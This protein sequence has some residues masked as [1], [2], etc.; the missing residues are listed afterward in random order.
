MPGRCRRTRRRWNGVQGLG[1]GCRGLRCRRRDG[2]HVMSLVMLAMLVRFGDMRWWG[3]GARDRLSELSCGTGVATCRQSRRYRG[4]NRHQ[5]RSP[6]PHLSNL[7]RT[8]STEIRS[9]N[10]L[11][12][13]LTYGGTTLREGVPAD[14][15]RANGAATHAS[16]IGTSPVR[17]GLPTNTVSFCASRRCGRDL[18]LRPIGPS[19]IPARGLLRL[20]DRVR[21]ADGSVV[22]PKW[23]CPA[24]ALLAVRAQTL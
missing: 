17:R 21:R 19:A 5:K 13:D 2:Y 8:L 24:R 16:M 6:V 23:R 14:P 20:R 15:P 11:G 1:L 10:P 7:K 9:V 3:D 22:G 18:I 12:R 4:G